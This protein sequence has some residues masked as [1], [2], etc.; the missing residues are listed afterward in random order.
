MAGSVSQL[1]QFA[2]DT[3]A[4]NYAVSVNWT[5]GDWA[6]IAVW[7]SE[8]ACTTT[9]VDSLGNTFNFIGSEREAAINCR[10]H[11]YWANITTG[12]AA[13]LTAAWFS[14][15]TPFGALA[16][17]NRQIAIKRLAGVA[18]FQIGGASDVFSENPTRAISI[19]N[20]SQPAYLSMIGVNMQ[21]GTFTANIAAGWT[22][23]GFITGS[24]GGGSLDGRCQGKSVAV[25]GVQTGQLINASLDRGVAVMAIFTETIT[26]PTVTKQPANAEVYGSRPIALVAEFNGSDT[27]QWYDNSTGSFA[28]I[29]GATASTLLFQATSGMNGRQF[30]AIATNTAGNVQTN[31]V[32][33]TFLNAQVPQMRTVY[34]RLPRG[35]NDVWDQL[36]ASVILD[37][38]V[39][40]N[41]TVSNG[42]AKIWTGTVWSSKPV[43]YWNG[44]AWTTKPLKR[45][46]GSSWV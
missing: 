31:T 35:G 37:N 12:G 11:H 22:D 20:T 13:T 25:V 6:H 8:A 45:W 40:D 17:T 10:V 30:Y 42:L 3:S 26:P 16:V 1:L 46:N 9:L 38:D 28:A 43:K 44:S 32:T 36:Q 39:F 2:Q 41:V 23:E 33:L 4:N 24:G 5:A 29:S 14:D 7:A 18:G 19:S 15:V 34:E 27:V 21:S